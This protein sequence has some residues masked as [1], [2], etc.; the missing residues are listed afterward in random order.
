MAN[1]YKEAI[2]DMGGSSTRF[3]IFKWE[4]NRITNE[5]S[6]DIHKNVLKEIEYGKHDNGEK[7]IAID[8]NNWNTWSKE[9]RQSFNNQ[10]NH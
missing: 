9:V 10:L 8:F 6:N 5:S 1:V 2:V 4:N 7:K 3:R